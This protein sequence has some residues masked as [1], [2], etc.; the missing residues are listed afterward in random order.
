MN[1]QNYLSKH[2]E[3]LDKIFKNTYL[4]HIHILTNCDF[5]LTFSKSSLGGIIISLNNDK[6]FIE[7][8]KE[9]YLFTNQ[10]SFFARIKQK[11]LNSKILSIEVI[12]NDNIVCFSFLKTTDTYDKISKKFIQDMFRSD[13]DL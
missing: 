7:L 9:K 10:N 13:N 12:N 3:N 6:P 4:N 2:I 1:S 8:T 5:E 11:I